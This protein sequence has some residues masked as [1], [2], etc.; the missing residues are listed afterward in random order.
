MKNSRSPLIFIF[1]TIFIDLLG[2]GIVLPLLPFYVK[3]IETNSPAWM[4]ANYAL[5]VGA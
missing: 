3:M 2:V 4:A 5:V 1:L